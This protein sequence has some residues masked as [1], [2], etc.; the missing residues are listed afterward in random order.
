MMYVMHVINKY[1]I[2]IS[3]ISLFIVVA[4]IWI[5]LSKQS[6]NEIPLRGVFVVGNNLNII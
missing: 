5:I 4:L 6:K 2:I 1:K 3:I